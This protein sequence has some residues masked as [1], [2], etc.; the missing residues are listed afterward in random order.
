MARAIEKDVSL[1]EGWMDTNHDDNKAAANAGVQEY[2]D[3]ELESL[4]SSVSSDGLEKALTAI[5]TNLP[6]KDALK[7]AKLFLARVESEL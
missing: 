5:S 4:M 3:E 6:A 1:P 2:Y 7:F